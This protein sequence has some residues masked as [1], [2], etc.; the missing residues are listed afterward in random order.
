MKTK[1]GTKVGGDI[2]DRAPSKGQ[3]SRE[4]ILLTAAKLATTRGLDGLS[5]GELAAEVGMS[6]SGLYAHF[7]SKEELEVATINTAAEIFDAEVLQ[8]ASSAPPGIK[9]LRAL[10]NGFLEHLERRVFPG[11]CFFVAVGTELKARPGPA[12]DR[13]IQITEM[14]LGLLR[15]CLLDAKAAKEI[16]SGADVTQGVFEIEASLLAAN[17][18]F[19]LSGDKAPLSQGR[20]GVE[21]VLARLGHKKVKA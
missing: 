13:V 7:K 3:L 12:R 8:R 4:A 9:R 17:L 14:W 15:Q 18:L 11:G 20:R 5:I 10:A 2:A 21:N 16:D 19:I 1:S 6:K